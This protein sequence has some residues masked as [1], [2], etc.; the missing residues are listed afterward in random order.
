MLD[1]T[2]NGVLEIFLGGD[3]VVIGNGSIG[4]YSV[5]FTT[6]NT[7]ELSLVASSGPQT[8][9]S[10]SVR[11]TTESTFG[12]MTVALPLTVPRLTITQSVGVGNLDS[13]LT[14]TG[15]DAIGADA[16]DINITTGSAIAG[17][18]DAGNM[19]FTTG[20]A[21]ATGQGGDFNFVA[22]QSGSS[23]GVK[24][25]DFTVTAG[26]CRG[27]GQAGVITL[28]VGDDISGSNDGILTLGQVG[29]ENLTFDF[30]T[31]NTI[32]LNSTTGVTV[33]TIPFNLIIGGTAPDS[34]FEVD[35]PIGTA[36][37]TVTGNTTL[38]N[39]HSTILVNASGNVT[40]TLP[41]AASSYNNTDGIGRTYRIKKIDADADDVDIDG[42]GSETI[43][44]DLVVTLN[45]QYESID[46]QSDGSNWHIL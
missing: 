11:K 2:A 21:T 35:G 27:T 4:S 14:V 39:T 45:A 15:A 28:L 19:N 46:I 37:E 41:T 18:G 12:G 17:S 3:S 22:G 7:N 38:N 1:S 16:G 24:G 5:L 44:G 13:P 31:A 20:E 43:D 33:L 8:L 40:I 23:T 6:I 29:G 26:E 42:N 30:S 10:I 25:G 34:L 36:I 32:T 9:T